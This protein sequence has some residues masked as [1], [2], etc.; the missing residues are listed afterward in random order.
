MA[1]RASV[2]REAIRR[3]RR[4]QGQ[5]VSNRELQS[6][7]SEG[8]LPEEVDEAKEGG[9]NSESNDAEPTALRAAPRKAPDYPLRKPKTVVPLPG[10]S[11]RDGETSE[12][13]RVDEYDYKPKRK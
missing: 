13:R 1:D 9:G 2:L 4:N 3:V 10:G 11:S 6:E 7:Q 12:E 8:K 5:A